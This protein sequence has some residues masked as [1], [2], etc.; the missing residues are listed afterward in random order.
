ML[1]VGEQIDRLRLHGDK[2]G[3]RVVAGRL[4]AQN[5]YRERIRPFLPVL[6]MK[7]PVGLHDT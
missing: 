1:R 2:S 4:A 7:E 5:D 3:A 6:S